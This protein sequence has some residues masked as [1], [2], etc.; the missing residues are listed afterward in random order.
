MAIEEN[1]PA[2]T[3]TD[4]DGFAAFMDSL[5]SETTDL[6]LPIT[7]WPQWV[8][9]TIRGDET[10]AESG[11]AL[12]MRIITTFFEAVSKQNVELVTMFIK[13]GWVSPDVPNAAGETPLIAAIV[14]GNG[15]MVCS[16]IGL[17]ARVDGYGRFE[18]LERTPLMVAAATGRLA[19][20]KLLTQEFG[21]DDA[22]VAPD[23]Q[24]A[25]R[26]AA[27]NGHREVVEY[28]PAR[29]GGA[30][31]RWQAHH[32]MAVRRMKKAAAKIYR[33]FKILLWDVPRFLFWSC[34]KHMVVLPVW[35]SCK[36]CWE[37]KHRFGGWCKRQAK[38]MPGRVKRAGKA[39]WQGV[40]K[41]PGELWEGA[42]AVGRGLKKIPGATKKFL[43][44]IW[45]FIKRIP[46]AIKV[47]ALWIW[48][49]LKK[50]G[51]AVGN[52][53]TRIMS[54]VHTALMAVLDYFRS[55]TLKD[56][57][58]GICAVFRAIFVDLP[59]AIWS[60]IKAAGEMTF[61][62]LEGLFGCVGALIW[63]FF[64]GLF[65]V[66]KYVPTQLWKIICSMGSSIAKGFHEIM[67][68]FNP[69]L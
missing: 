35:K 54:A 47:V 46:G 39:V 13:R 12:Q 37:N 58:N 36:W 24:L 44:A 40:K 30:W 38:E 66:A 31:R 19:L 68:W 33:F 28:L 6:Q 57:W 9:L 22:V 42:K 63:Y 56:V 52:V 5:S 34:P 69:K 45:R 48:S 62:V 43:L 17:G 65:W 53:F 11:T 60:G 4:E 55:I 10:A 26:L 1:V 16:L 20:V 67:V 59:Q 15:A 25:L 18:G 2:Y 27:D 21:A 41:A 14:A 29:R 50:I 7:T 23:G 8:S 51:V 49:W 32:E 3:E 61:K 64:V